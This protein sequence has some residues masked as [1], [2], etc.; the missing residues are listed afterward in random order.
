MIFR[1][2]ALGGLIALATAPV[3]AEV[4]RNVDKHGNVT[5]SDEPSE[6]S[7][8]VE[9]KPVTTVTLPKLTDVTRSK[10]EANPVTRKDDSKAGYEAVS[11]MAP[12]NDEA[13]HSGSGDIQFQVASTPA[14]KAGHKYELTLDGQPVAQSSSGS[15]VISNIF[16][17]THVA[18]VHIID[19]HG[20]R[21]KTGDNIRFTV[22]R[23][24]AL[25]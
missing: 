2:L 23:P 13:F 5:F 7:E 15:I 4:Y 24:S 10:A 12:R 18:Q 20:M 1:Y 17:G 6:G 14:L 22:H 8:P 3:A 19:E 16:R 21:V 25:K 9:V 11:F